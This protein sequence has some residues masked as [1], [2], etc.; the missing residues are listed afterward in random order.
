MSFLFQRC[1]ESH[2]SNLDSWISCYTAASLAYSTCMLTHWGSAPDL[3]DEGHNLAP[4]REI[5]EPPRCKHSK[6]G[7]WNWFLCRM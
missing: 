7:P 2:V 3:Q 6:L 4:N 5:D 1:R